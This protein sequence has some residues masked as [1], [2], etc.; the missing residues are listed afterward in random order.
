MVD[1]TPYRNYP[2]IQEDGREPGV[3]I[4]DIIHDF[5]LAVD[6]DINTILEDQDTV[7]NDVQS[8]LDTIRA[9]II[10]AENDIETVNTARIDGD[11]TTEFTKIASAI[12]RDGQDRITAATEGNKVT[13]LVTFNGDGTINTWREVITLSTGIVTRDYTAAYTDGLCTGVTFT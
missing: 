13:S 12:T 10:V 11:K 3:N 4:A 7:N 8:D 2:I 6:S 1:V 5:T 9:D